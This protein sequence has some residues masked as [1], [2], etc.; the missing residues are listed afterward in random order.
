V[1]T[2][3]AGG[4]RFARRAARLNHWLAILRSRAICTRERK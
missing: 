4:N 3:L 2:R 1:A